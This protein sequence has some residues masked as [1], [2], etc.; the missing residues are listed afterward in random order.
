MLTNV[1]GKTSID[2]LGHR[3]D[4]NGISPLPEKA[5]AIADYSMARSFK[6]LRRFL[7]IVNYYSRFI[8]DC[9][10]L[11]QP[12]TDLLQ[13]RS[14]K[15]ESTQGAIDAFDKIKHALSNA[16]APSHLRT[17]VDTTHPQD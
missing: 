7:G 1:F 11:L 16:T 3:V 5:Q 8:P 10:G 14:P 15:F 12:L 4:C 2:F 13:G 9:S 17:D 6:S